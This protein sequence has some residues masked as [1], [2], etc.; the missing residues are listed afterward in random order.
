MSGSDRA[1]VSIAV[2]VPPAA[3]FRIF[4]E[5]IDQWWIDGLKYRVFGGE[6]SVV[7][8]ETRPGG[9][10]FERCGDAVVR[11]GEVLAWEPPS[12]LVL[13]WRGANLKGPDKTEV[14]VLFE[15]RERGTLVTL[16]HS[17]WS[18][19]RDDHP[20]RHGQAS[21]AFLRSLGM[22]WS[23]LLCSMRAHAATC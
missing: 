2:G 19:I 1:R 3:A 18:R 5:D 16:T 23:D 4:T 14:E 8:L 15:A 7:Y 20:V 10:L 12:R 11:T 6:R 17:G 13:E 9:G 22:W 21:G